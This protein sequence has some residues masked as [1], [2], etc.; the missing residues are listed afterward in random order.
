MG[1]NSS[2]GNTVEENFYALTHRQAG[3]SRI[4]NVA[5]IHADH[6]KVGEIKRTN[7]ELITALRLPEVNA[8]SRTCS[9]GD[10]RLTR[11]DCQCWSY[12]KRPLS[13]RT[14]YGIY[15]WRYGYDRKLFLPL[16]WWWT[17]AT[18]YHYSQYRRGNSP[19]RRLCRHKRRCNQREYCL[20]FFG[21][22]YNN[23][24]Q[25]PSY[26]QS[27]LSHCRGADALSKFT[28]NGFNTWW[29]SRILTAL[30]STNIARA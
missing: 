9:L 17:P 8:Y 26:R 11:S 7:A 23:G 2:I 4:E 25:P 13:L 30:L 21:K 14:H 10:Y 1:I 12:P 20:L 24:Y 6:I 29:F 18:L 22:R 5:T 15:C 3:I 16:W 28:I 19:N 27:Q